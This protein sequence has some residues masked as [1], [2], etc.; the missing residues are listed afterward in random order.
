[1]KTIML[2]CLALLSFVNTYGQ[3]I[4]Q[5]QVP[6][7]IVEKFQ[8]AFPK[9]LDLEWEMDGAMYKAEFEIGLLDHEVWYD[10]NAKVVRHK[11]DISQTD[12]PASIR[13]KINNDFAAYKIDDS[14]KISS[15]EGTNYFVE[16]KKSGEEW[17]ILFDAAGNIVSKVMD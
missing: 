6:A 12:I 1:M 4:P 15:D 11:E 7:S 8:K 9:A 2:F 13:T 17:D 10:S 3:D 14:K 16:L 5:S